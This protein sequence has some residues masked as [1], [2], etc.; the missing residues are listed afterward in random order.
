VKFIFHFKD[1]VAFELLCLFFFLFYSFAK[2]T[3]TV[4]KREDKMAIFEW[5]LSFAFL[6][7]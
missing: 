5:T 1:R 7:K 6:M 4:M 2:K 3:L